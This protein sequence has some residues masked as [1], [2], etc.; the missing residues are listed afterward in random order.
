MRYEGDACAV[1][2]GRSHNVKH[3]RQS[4]GADH[5]FR[6]EIVAT[7]REKGPLEY[8]VHEQLQEK[9]ST[10]GAGIEW[11]NVPAE[12]AIQCINKI[13]AEAC[14]RWSSGRCHADQK[15]WS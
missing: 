15:G 6:M 3:R 13:I 11:F 5:N 9:R 8:T 10:K 1:K 14:K 12:E 4:M 2:I 7:F